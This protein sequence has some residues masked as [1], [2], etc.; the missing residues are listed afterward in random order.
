MGT[1]A[2]IFVA[3]SSDVEKIKTKSFYVYDKL[4]KHS[5]IEISPDDNELVLITNDASAVK[6]FERYDLE[7]GFNPFDY[8]E[9][10][11]EVLHH[12]TCPMTNEAEADRAEC[13]CDVLDLVM[14]G[15]VR[16]TPEG[17]D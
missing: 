8:C 1:L 10:L 15:M 6:M 3:Q 16:D 2:G 7:T 5:E 11:D 17:S 9:D 4:G 14:P 12:D 13:T